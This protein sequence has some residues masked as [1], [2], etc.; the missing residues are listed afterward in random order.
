MY[1]RS[2]HHDIPFGHGGFDPVVQ[3][4]LDVSLEHDPEIDALG[5]VHDVDVVRRVARG[6]EVDDAAKHAR[7]VDQA[8]PFA[9]N[10]DKGTLSVGRD[11]V[12]LV[13][14]GEAGDD[15]RRRVAC[16]VERIRWGQ[17]LVAV[18]DGLAV[19]IMSWRIP[20]SV[21]GPSAWF[22]NPINFEELACDYSSGGWERH[23]ERDPRICIFK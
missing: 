12:R 20:L 8:D 10:L 23:V 1:S 17:D 4:Q 6:G 13:E 16:G 22:S 5:P 21:K 9:M 2:L 14:V 18:D 19:G 11:P 3:D 15:A 7:L